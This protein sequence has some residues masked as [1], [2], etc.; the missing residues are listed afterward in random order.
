MVRRQHPAVVS[1]YA[2]ATVVR[3]L[4]C[5]STVSESQCFSDHLPGVVKEVGAELI[6]GWIVSDDLKP[7]HVLFSDTAIR[8]VHDELPTRPPLVD[9]AR[10]DLYRG[11]S[12]CCDSLTLSQPS[13]DEHIEAVECAGTRIRSRHGVSF[14]MKVMRRGALPNE[15][16][17]KA[18]LY[19]TR[20]RHP[21][22]ASIVSFSA[23]L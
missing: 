4:P 9:V 18:G 23:A 11:R 3:C 16:H 22:L 17:E 21:T 20:E 1:E 13:A 14:L 6:G 19:I 2:L 15:Y 12:W 8:R 10:N 5:P 7:A